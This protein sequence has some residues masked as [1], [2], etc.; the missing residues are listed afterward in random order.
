MG[1]LRL[2][3]L[4]A[5]ALSGAQLVTA[6][7][8]WNTGGEAALFIS[9]AVPIDVPR[10]HVFMSYNFEASYRLPKKWRR[11][12][13]HYKSIHNFGSGE[14]CLLRLICESNAARLGEHNGVLGS[15]M[16]VM[17]SPS[18]SKD[19][20]LPPRYYLAEQRGQRDECELYEQRCKR[21]LLD[22]ITRP[23]THFINT[24][25]LAIK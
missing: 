18:S 22:L 12:R 19:E 24:K 20:Q 17:F 7:L 21:S 13:H 11:H 10:S 6:V 1:L 25:L 5:L 9:I 3:N 2:F 8:V 23:I 15:L 16:Q 14:L 4:V